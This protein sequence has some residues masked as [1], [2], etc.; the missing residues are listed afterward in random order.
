VLERVEPG[1]QQGGV[2]GR[3]GPG[4]AGW[5]RVQRQQ[6]AERVQPHPHAGARALAG[7]VLPGGGEGGSSTGVGVDTGG[8]AAPGGERGGQPCGVPVGHGR[9]H[10]RERRRV[11]ERRGHRAVRL[12]VPAEQRGGA[13]ERA[14]AARPDRRRGGEY[15][16]VLGGAGPQETARGGEVGFH[17]LG[18]LPGHVSSSVPNPADRILISG[19]CAGRTAGWPIGEDVR[20]VERQGG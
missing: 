15:H 7:V 2:L 9:Q 18:E 5:R 1:Q 16:R 3:G 10:H 4:L 12:H 20:Q 17:V 8:L 13:A 11:Q 6:L 14:G 19:R